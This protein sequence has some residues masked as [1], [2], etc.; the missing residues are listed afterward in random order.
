MQ[1]KRILVMHILYLYIN[2]LINWFICFYKFVK[3]QE[4]V[5]RSDERGGST[6]GPISSTHIDIPSVDVGTPIL[7]MHSIR[8][9]GSVDDHYSIYKTFHKFYEI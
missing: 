6:L 9:L 8:E 5:N 3:Y 7:A 1:I 4:F 2:L